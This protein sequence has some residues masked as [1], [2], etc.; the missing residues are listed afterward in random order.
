MGRSSILEEVGKEQVSGGANFL[1]PEMLTTSTTPG[2]HVWSDFNRVMPQ[3]PE[4]E[5]LRILFVIDEA[6]LLGP[7][8]VKSNQLL[9]R[10]RAVLYRLKTVYS[11]SW[12]I[13]VMLLTLIARNGALFL[14]L[15]GHQNESR[16]TLLYTVWTSLT[17]L[18]ARWKCPWRSWLPRKA[19]LKWPVQ[20]R[21]G[22][23]KANMLMLSS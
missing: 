4:K 9:N 12:W 2:E 15:D 16:R 7:Q 8:K 22:S 20:S 19:S 23:S 6:R 3:T 14:F 13:Q 5:K 11:P 17:S 21:C 1:N 10:L 18:R